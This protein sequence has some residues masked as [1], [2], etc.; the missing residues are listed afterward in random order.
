MN[1]CQSRLF[2][3]SFLLGAAA[4]FVPVAPSMA[5]SGPAQTR[6]NIVLILSDDQAWT[7]YG[8]MGHPDIKTPNLDQLA[9]N[10]L[11]FDHGY[12]A[13]P[14]CRPS[15]ASMVTG[16]FPS[17]NGITANDVTGGMFEI[18]A[19]GETVLLLGK[20][21]P[22]D[23]PVRERFHRLPSFIRSL[24]EHGYLTH[25]SGKWW[26][27]SYRD[28]GFTHGMTEGER[29]GDNGLTIGRE[30][31]RPIERF[32]D[33]ALADGKPLFLWYAPFLPHTPHHPPD[34][35]LEKYLTGGRARD[36]ASYYAMIEWFDETCGELMNI[37]RKNKIFENTVIIYICDNGWA[38]ASTTGDWPREQAYSGFAMR[39]KGSPYENGIR[40]PILVSWPGVVQPAR[41]SGFAYSIDLYPTIAAIAGFEAPGDLSGINLLDLDAVRKR[42]ALLGSV[43]ASHNM[44]IGNPDETLQYRWCIEGDWK[45]LLRYHGKDTTD[46]R[47]LHAWDTAP[48]RLF[49]LAEDP[50]EKNDLAVAEPGIVDRL[51][52]KIEDW[53]STLD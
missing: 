17:Q 32:V 37:L 24:T 42:K 10:S 23:R 40:T 6:P 8:F 31:M 30:G 5:Q 52:G 49:N 27:G 36:V 15:L 4:I 46:Y 12:V 50:A 44:T 13:S 2:S 38:P 25:Q 28:G 47:I 43:H 45:L 3:A 35:F 18:N 34:R 39:S 19:R 33:L 7:D 9:A 22:L 29:H 21:E 41:V 1:P 16:R 11:R 48:C 51:R 20:R 14:L 53:Q 26:E